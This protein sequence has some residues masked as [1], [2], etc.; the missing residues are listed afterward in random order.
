MRTSSELRKRITKA[1]S[2]LTQVAQQMPALRMKPADRT[3]W[4]QQTAAYDR[5]IIQLRAL[6]QR[7]ADLG[8]RGEE[9]EPR[10]S[11]RDEIALVGQEIVK[12][13]YA[14]QTQNRQFPLLSNIMKSRHDTAKSIITNIL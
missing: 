10:G 13:Q 2:E 11:G 6:D 1:I 9:A 5:A 7:L 8:P 4:Q 12:L 14:F 3:A